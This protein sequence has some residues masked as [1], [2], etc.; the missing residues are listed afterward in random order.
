MD[1]SR[2]VIRGGVAGRERLRLLANVLR[3][4]TRGL[5][6][7]VGVAARMNCI[8]VGCGGGDVSFE[9]AGLVGPHGNV[10]GLD[11][12]DVKLNLA[13][14]EA[15]SRNLQNVTFRRV[16]IHDGDLREEFGVAYTR[17]LL[18]H[19][20]APAIALEKM[21]GAVRPDGLVVVED[22]DFRGHFSH[23]ESAALT[24]YV[25]L[26]ARVVQRRGGDPHIGPRLP[27]LLHDAG[28][29]KIEVHVVQ[30]VGMEGEIKLINPITL[31]NIADSVVED[32][33]AT[34]DEVSAIIAELYAFARTP[35]TLV[36]L[37]RIVQ[38]W[39]VKRM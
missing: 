18:T 38:A 19:L 36:S 39:G 26:Y 33:L 2:Y 23:P 13:R 12:D 20:A 6:E 17:F 8:D 16:D 27:G 29:E 10:V 21:C 37:P 31:E 34:R 7:R 11:I 35:N 32:G 14:E 30:P 9:L 15:A 4:T 28:L 22:I 24:R 3:P 25:D 1:A 5:L